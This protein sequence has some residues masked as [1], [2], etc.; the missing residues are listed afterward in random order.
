MSNDGL[1]FKRPG[2]SWAAGS[3]FL[4][5]APERR[6]QPASGRQYGSR[7]EGGWL[8]ACVA[9]PPRAGPRPPLPARR[10]SWSARQPGRWSTAGSRTVARQR[11]AG[12]L[13]EC[14]ISTS[15]LLGRHRDRASLVRHPFAAHN[16][17]PAWGSGP[18]AGDWRGTGGGGGSPGGGPTQT[19][20]AGGCWRCN[21]SCIPAAAGLG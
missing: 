4:I 16:Q 17:R 3:R 7:R 20:W 6:W 1:G 5:E 10:W 19:R 12:W 9:P 2:A 15:Q 14:F 13:R 8:E 18:R 11:H 21:R